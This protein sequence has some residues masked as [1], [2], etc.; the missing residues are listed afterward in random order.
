M[1]QQ[2]SHMAIPIAGR[3]QELNLFGQ[4][5]AKALALNRKMPPLCICPYVMRQLSTSEPMAMMGTPSVEDLHYFDPVL[6][7]SLETTLFEENVEDLM[8]PW[9]DVPP[10][11]RPEF[12]TGEDL[13]TTDTVH[14]YVQA[15]V[16]SYFLGPVSGAVEAIRR[17]LWS[18]FG[19]VFRGGPSTTFMI[20][21]DDWVRVSCGLPDI[22]VDDL[23]ASIEFEA[24][25]GT[26]EEPTQL[27]QDIEKMLREWKGEADGDRKLHSFVE[28]ATS[29][30]L[31][32]E[33]VIIHIV[34]MACEEPDNKLPEAATCSSSICVPSYSSID[35][36]RDRFN[37]AFEH[38][39]DGFWMG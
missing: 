29:S 35:V 34:P 9:A 7:R 26:D 33:F 8:L 23:L 28:Y 2:R 31:L 36:L 13:V 10:L 11:F 16:E 20:D 14:Q 27:R 12:V 5:L 4:I 15:M 37:K 22:D 24:S 21:V 18:V 25:F 30:P 6:A 17:G 38:M 32:T 19:H 39:G 3:E 1:F